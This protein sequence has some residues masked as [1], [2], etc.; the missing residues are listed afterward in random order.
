MPTAAGLWPW[1]T[2]LPGGIAEWHSDQLRALADVLRRIADNCEAM[3]SASTN[4]AP[5]RRAYLLAG[6]ML[7]SGGGWT[8]A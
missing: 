4:S 1:S 7:H 2:N 8:I 6:V 5:L 3:P